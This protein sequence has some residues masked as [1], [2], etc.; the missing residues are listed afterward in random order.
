MPKGVG[1]YIGDQEVI[2]VSAVRSATG[3]KIKS[4]AIE[5]VTAEISQ[6]AIA[7][8][9]A[10][11]LRRLNPRARA[12]MWAL[13]KIQEPGAYVTAAVDPVHVATRHFMMPSIPKAEQASA[14]R[15]EASR[16]LPFKLSESI[17]DYRVRESHKSVVSV[18]AAAIRREILDESL[19]DLRSASAKVLMIEPLY[20]AVSRAFLAVSML[21]KEREK[22]Y[23]LVV[24]QSDGNVNITFSSKGIVYLSRDFRLG[25]K[26]EEDKGRFVEEIRASLDYFYKLTGGETVGQI[27]FSGA[28]DLGLWSEHL[29]RAFNY[30]IRFDTARLSSEKE[31]PP[32]IFSK[33]FAAFGLAL[34]GLGLDSP[35]GSIQLLP[36]EER[37][38]E[39]RKMLIFLGTEAAIVLALFLLVRFAIFQPYMNHLVR[40]SEAVVAPIAAE[41]PGAV[42]RSL[43]ELTAEKK[44]LEPRVRQL[45]AF[46]ASNEPVSGTLSAFGQGLPQNVLLDQITFEKTVRDGGKRSGKVDARLNVR[47]YCYLGSAE[48]ETAVVG[49]WAKSLAV[50]KGLSDRFSEIKLEEIRRERVRNREMTR[51]Q[52]IGE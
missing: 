39:F 9:E 29:E 7:G 50:K 46:I 35:L 16:Y 45:K 22:V 17:M 33:I 42:S 10:H 41:D 15:N 11:R 6:E 4:F 32:E 12:V 21:G 20:C 37:R 48:K 18:T 43:E 13:Q 24:L 14:I 44:V 51:F 52:I 26:I 30:T 49:G 31:I 47:G 27:F 23:G 40:D 1:V 34:Q 28:G 36:K 38:T 19:T 3:P 25:G 5:P 2:A 8:K